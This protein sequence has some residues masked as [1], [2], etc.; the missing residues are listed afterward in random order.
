VRVLTGD[1]TRG[2]S[3]VIFRKSLVVLQFSISIVLI[4]VTAVVYQQVQF[5][6]NVPLGFEKEQVVVLRATSPS[7]GLGDQWETLKHELLAH[8]EI[9]AITASSLTPGQQNTN[10]NTVRFEGGAPEGRSG[11]AFMWVDYGFFEAYGVQVLAGR[12]FSSELGTDRTQ[13]ATPDNPRTSGSFVLNASAARAFGWTPEQAVGKWFE[14]SMGERLARSA[15]G[16]IIGVVDDAR[17]ESVHNEIRP[18]VFLVPS[19]Q[20]VARLATQASV[21][22]TGRDV[23]GTLAYIDAKWKELM[24][25]QPIVRRFL[26]DDFDALYAREERQQQMFT[27]FALLAVFI[28][29]LGLFGLASFATE[30]RTKEIGIRKA[31]GGTAVDIVRLFTRELTTLVLVANLIAWPIAY[32]FMRRWLDNFAYRI[33]MGVLVYAAAALAAFAIAWLTVGAVAT[34]AAVAKPVHSLRY[35]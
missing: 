21:R 25:G 15:R 24:P 31:I 22:I 2:R 1:V 26:D 18:L 19:E 12:P 29:C 5:A 20:G 8:P 10:G 23:P 13:L 7:V 17:L 35:E 28:A 34:R 33:D 11:T 16:P 32:V 6:R 9:T 27:Y 14:F 30:Q 3:A 4:I